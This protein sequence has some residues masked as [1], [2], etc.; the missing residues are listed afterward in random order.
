[1]G[2]HERITA[3][4]SAEMAAGVRAAIDVGAYASVDAVIREALTFW[5]RDAA[6][7]QLDGERLRAMIAEGDIGE[8]EDADSF[9][10]R[11]D[12]EVRAL[13]SPAR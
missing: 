2:K 11:L 13:E 10:D 3:E 7:A 6:P 5:L 12:A 8:G 4:I 1:M 9:F